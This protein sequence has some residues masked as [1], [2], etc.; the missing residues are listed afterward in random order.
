ML[1]S[2]EEED[3][4]VRR[5]RQ[6]G[7]EED[8]DVTEDVDDVREA[9]DGQEEAKVDDDEDRR[10]PQY[11]PKRGNFYEHDDRE[12][13]EGEA[14]SKD[15]KEGSSKD[16]DEGK[17][18][19]PRKQRVWRSEAVEKWGHDKFMELEQ[20]PKSKDE[21]VSAYGYDIRNEDNAPRAR[22]R[23]RYGRGPNKYT[24]KWEDM[25]AYGPQANQAR[26]QGGREGT[27]KDLKDPKERRPKGDK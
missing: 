23:R 14:G 4:E 1:S 13:S 26:Q 2:E 9:G 25:E 6:S 19:E 24:R 22:R 3:K 20:E 7:S 16:G 10:N 21:L 27:G 18:G 8:C 5:R 15:G 11:I 12:D 17:D